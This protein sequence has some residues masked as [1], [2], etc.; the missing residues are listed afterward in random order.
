MMSNN[1][2]VKN[3]CSYLR[4]V[5]VAESSG[6]EMPLTIIFLNV[7]LN[8]GAANKLACVTGLLPQI[9]FR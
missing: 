7:K 1:C 2:K 5:D 9:S 4:D 6:R 3:S 8:I